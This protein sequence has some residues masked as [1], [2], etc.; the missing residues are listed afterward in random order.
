VADG[1]R[2]PVKAL[3]RPL[4]LLGP[5]GAG[6]GTQAREVARIY[7]VPHL[8]TGDMF[9]DHV[10]KGTDLGRRAKPIMESGQLVPDEIVLEMFEERVARPDCSAGFVLDGFPRTVPQAE[11]LE[12]IL[13]HLPL[14][15][16]LAV[17]L[18]LNLDIAVARIAG[19]RTCKNCGATYSTDG[20]AQAAPA[21]CTV[22][23]G[24]LVQRQDD[25]E[26]VVRKRLEG[27]E[28]QARPLVDFYRRRG[29]LAELDGSRDIA[30]VQHELLAL[31]DK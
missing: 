21:K 9:R 19:R 24:E 16:L 4:V 10:A 3:L 23:G 27:Y 17:N 22:C 2:A 5:P 1:Q 11:R 18:V 14:G 25:H 8:S 28:Q 13:S 29:Q 15:K 26:D 20:I 12:E 6:K 7:K 31:L 30:T